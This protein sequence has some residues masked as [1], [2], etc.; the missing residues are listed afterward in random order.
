MYNLQ[1]QCKLAQRKEV[2][3]PKE[4]YTYG[5]S[6]KQVF[7]DEYI[8]DTL[9]KRNKKFKVKYFNY[10]YQI[11]NKDLIDNSKG[12]LN[13]SISDL[14]ELIDDNSKENWENEIKRRA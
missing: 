2:K 4:M 13:F 5:L 8:I 6:C 7:E 12:D 11:L 9:I 10:N 3:E 14:V 1:N